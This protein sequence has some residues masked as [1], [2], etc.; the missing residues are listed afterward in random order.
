M[1]KR[2]SVQSWYSAVEMLTRATVQFDLF[3]TAA[4]QRRLAGMPTVNSVPMPQCCLQFLLI[5]ACCSCCEPD[6]LSSSHLRV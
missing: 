4:P 1:I 2:Y 3:S 5:A 6:L